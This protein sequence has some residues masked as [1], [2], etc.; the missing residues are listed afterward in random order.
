MKILYLGDIVGNLGLET[1]EKH[2]DEL[3]KEYNP[4]L[5]FVN[6][7]NT[8]KG[9]GLNLIDYKRLMKLNIALLSMGNHTFRQE[10]INDFIDVAKIV[11]PLNIKDVKGKG[12]QI[13]NYNGKH[14][15]LINLIG[16]YLMNMK[17][18]ITNPFK[19]ID[20]LLKNI[21]ADY[22]IVDMH[23]ETTSE[24]Q[25]MGYYLDGR[26]NAVVGTHTH[27]QTNDDRILPKGTLYI[28]DLGMCGS[29]DS[30]LGVKK[31]IIIDRFLEDKKA[32]FLLEENG[33]KMINGVLLDLDLKIII[34]VRKEYN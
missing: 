29:E 11:R 18:E 16:S 19:E 30:I 4:S 27:V 9:K 8:T 22:I 2:L 7:E 21:K 26:V 14:I 28:S 31:E 10:E 5:V 20:E 1:L 34:K 25:A 6:A 3:K 32:I 33:K 15:C 23:A 12:Y 24:K 17:E 13:I